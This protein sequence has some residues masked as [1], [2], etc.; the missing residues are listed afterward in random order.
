MNSYYE[1]HTALKEND[2]CPFKVTVEKNARSV[3]CNWHENI[4]IL[5][6]LDGA[7]MLQYGKDTLPMEP[8]DI[9]VV[10]SGIMHRPYS[11]SGVSYC[12]III[13]ERFCRENGLDTSGICFDRRFRDEQ[14]ARLLQSMRERSKE[15]YES[16]TPLTTAAL[17]CAALN[18]LVDLAARHCVTNPGP[19]RQAAP[20]EIY[21]KRALTYL[22]ENY[23]APIHLE[24]IA[25]LCGITKYYLAREFKRLT[26]QTVFTYANSLR[27]KKAQILLAQGKTATEA[28]LESGFESLPYFSRTYRKIMGVNPS[29]NRIP[30][31]MIVYGGKGTARD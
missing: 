17:R 24:Q 14:T 21:V 9:I 8:G 7:G 1:H 10:N 11:D 6:V 16:C 26:G 28:A 23:S 30:G 22:N 25:G 2:L 4:E 19:H 5:F 31:K 20:A 3:H 29:Q 12:V 27:C 18:L 13:D 15:H